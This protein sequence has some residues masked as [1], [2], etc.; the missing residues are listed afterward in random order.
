MAQ[1]EDMTGSGPTGKPSHIGRE[2]KDRF[3]AQSDLA[4]QYLDIAGVIVVALNADETVAMINRKGC[5]VLRRQESEIVGR[6]WFDVFT[7]ARYRENIRAVFNKLMAGEIR[8]AEYYENPVLTAGGEE[9][10]IVWHNSVLRDAEGGITGT[11]ASG[12]DVTERRR[13]EEALVHRSAE[14]EVL[15][16]ELESFAYSVA[17]HLRGPLRSIGDVSRDML[18]GR[19]ARLDAQGKDCLR[20]ICAAAERME[21]IIAD[22]LDF[23]G[24]IRKDIKRQRVDLSALVNAIAAEL[25]DAQGERRVDVIVQQGLTA[26][27]DEGLLRVALQ[28]LLGNAWKFTSTRSRARIEFGASQV[29]EQ[30]VFFIRDNGIGFDMSAAEGLFEPFRRLEG[31]VGFPGTGL[32]L[33]AVQRIV[34]RH[35]GRIWAE[36]KKGSGATF[37][38]TLG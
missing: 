38:F 32:G 36:A 25:R 5:E 26:D 1:S 13:V 16:K 35:G 2:A 27:G 9:R 4:R 15:N 20:R 11:L 24:A 33:V 8:P 12:E 23:A 34:S 6:N 37:Y 28:H 21:A 29:E 3:P 7:P 30:R 10:I 19:L 22:L 31:S 17:H 18:D 14:L